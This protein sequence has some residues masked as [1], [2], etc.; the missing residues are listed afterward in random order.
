MRVDAPAA[1]ASE[2][3]AAADAAASEGTT[4]ASSGAVPWAPLAGLLLTL[5]SGV[6]SSSGAPDAALLGSP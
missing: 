3:T 2:G 5:G 1:A 4:A 6:A